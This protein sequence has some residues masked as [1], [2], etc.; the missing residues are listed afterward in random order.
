[1]RLLH[2]WIYLA[3]QVSIMI[4]KFTNELL[5]K[6]LSV[7]HKYFFFAKCIRISLLSIFSFYIIEKTLIQ[8]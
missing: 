3:L 4:C 2:Q 8:S 7:D 5:N 1:M 6:F